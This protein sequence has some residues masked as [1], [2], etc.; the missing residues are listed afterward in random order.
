MADLVITAANVVPASTATRKT[1]TAGEAITAGMPVYIDASDNY[2]LKKADDTTAA[3]SAAV[4]IACNDAA[5]GQPLSYVEEGDLAVGAVLTVGV[6]YGLSDNAGKIRPLS[7]N[8]SGDYVTKLGLA[9][10]TSNLRVKVEA[11]GVTIPA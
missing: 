5:A 3:K 1:G 2:K 10:T 11:L 9:T 4:G 6:A 7:D 8:A